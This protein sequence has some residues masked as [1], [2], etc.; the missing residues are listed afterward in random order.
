[1]FIHD[2]IK[3]EYIRQGYLPDH[4]YHLI[5]DREMFDAFLV[6]EIVVDKDVAMKVKQVGPS[7][8]ES[9]R[10]YISLYTLASFEFV[11]EGATQSIIVRG[12]RQKLAD[13][14]TLF[15]LNCECKLSQEC[16][17]SVN[18]PMLYDSLSDDYAK[19]VDSIYYH[20]NTYVD[21]LN[22]TNVITLPGWVYSYMAGS[23]VGPNSSEADVHDLLALMNLHSINHE[24]SEKVCASCLAI[25]RKWITKL[26]PGKNIMRPPTIYGEPH[27]I[28]SLRISGLLADDV[29]V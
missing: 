13:F 28:K 1:M 9:P 16:Y 29:V 23:V 5:S 6:D 22:T 20:I 11:I 3:M 18:Y 14:N 8:W 24:F 15:S 17:F 10:S 21:S 27:V 26:P 2:V 25:S 7:L 12:N 4:P 19:L